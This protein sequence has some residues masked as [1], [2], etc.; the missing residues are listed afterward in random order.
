MYECLVLI[1]EIMSEFISKKLYSDDAY[2][3]EL[4]ISLLYTDIS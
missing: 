4:N 3:T 2:K 1:H